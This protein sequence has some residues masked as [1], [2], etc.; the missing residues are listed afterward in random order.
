MNLYG[1]TFDALSRNM[2]LRM[3]RQTLLSANIANAETPGYKPVDLQFE[4]ELATFLRT[5]DEQMKATQASHFGAEQEASNINGELVEQAGEVSA[6]GNAVDLERE[7]A[8]IANNSGNYRAAAR[9]VTK[10]LALVKYV[11][12]GTN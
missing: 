12:N 4:N 6:D 9:M 3:E 2:D 10:K 7:M 11:I 8:E 1:K 5:D